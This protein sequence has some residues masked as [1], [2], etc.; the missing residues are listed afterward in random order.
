MYTCVLEISSEYHSSVAVHYVFWNR[1]HPSLTCKLLLGLDWMAS[2][3][4]EFSHSSLPNTG[5]VWAT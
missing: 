2:M 4:Q 1:V 3:S 5:I